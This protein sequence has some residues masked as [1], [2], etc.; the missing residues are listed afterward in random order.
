MVFDWLLLQV[1][2]IGTK[3]VYETVIQS[4]EVAWDP[5]KQMSQSDT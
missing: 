3:K 2:L 4:H 1:N 5:G